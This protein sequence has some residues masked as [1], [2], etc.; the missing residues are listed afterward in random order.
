MPGLRRGFV[1]KEAF[2]RLG[3]SFE[4]QTVLKAALA[5]KVVDRSGTIYLVSGSQA[6]QMPT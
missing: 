3:A 4:F 5:L 1:A 2:S 6:L